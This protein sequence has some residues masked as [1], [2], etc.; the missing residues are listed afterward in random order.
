M[1]D[2]ETPLRDRSI[3]PH[4]AELAGEHRGERPTPHE[5]QWGMTEEQLASPEWR[6][7]LDAMFAGELERAQQP[8]EADD[9]AELQ[10]RLDEL[11]QR[12]SRHGED[13]KTV[14]AEYW[15]LHTMNDTDGS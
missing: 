2:D 10:R 12:I 6:A 3:M 9:P 13:A 5:G 8:A 7:Q 14:I 11:E 1:N 15:A 4:V